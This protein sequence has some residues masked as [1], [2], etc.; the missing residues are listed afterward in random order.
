MLVQTNT[1]QVSSLILNSVYLAS[2]LFSYF[3]F[4]V[5]LSPYVIC[6]PQVLDHF[7]ELIC[8]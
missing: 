6:L 8:T 3:A 7:E 4:E 2:K 1:N 5:C